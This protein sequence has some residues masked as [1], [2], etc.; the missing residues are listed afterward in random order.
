M[1]R[2]T[3]GS[4]SAQTEPNEIK[5]TLNLLTF[6]VFWGEGRGDFSLHTLVNQSTWNG[7]SENG[8]WNLIWFCNLGP[9]EWL[10]NA[11]Q[12]HRKLITEPIMVPS[13]PCKHAIDCEKTAETW[14][15]YS[16]VIKVCHEFKLTYTFMQNYKKLKN[17][18]KF[19]KKIFLK[20]SPNKYKFFNKTEC[21]KTEKCNPVQ[22]CCSIPSTRLERRRQPVIPAQKLAI[23]VELGWIAAP[24]HHIIDACIGWGS[25]AQPLVHLVLF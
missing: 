18:K 8:D 5:V 17:I 21:T 4:S 22:N 9:D 15:K 20:V 14:A 2:T 1:S 7:T 12:K 6:Q 19:L 25:V 23:S 10:G 11:T 16:Q 3:L 13:N 24:A